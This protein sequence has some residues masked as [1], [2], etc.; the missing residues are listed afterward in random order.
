MLKNLRRVGY[1]VHI[2]V[3]PDQTIP[4]ITHYEVV[5][6]SCLL[7]P[8]LLFSFFVCLFVWFGLVF[9]DAVS[10]SSPGCPG[11]RSVDQASL[12]TCP[13]APAS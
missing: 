10:L 8:S 3:R 13:P 11:T 9:P 6:P 4:N 7:P 1:P 2:H 5:A 12:S